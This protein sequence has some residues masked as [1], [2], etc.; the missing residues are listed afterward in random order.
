MMDD[1]ACTHLG[2]WRMYRT[3]VNDPATVTGY[4][5][6]VLSYVERTVVC[7]DCGDVIFRKRWTGTQW[8]EHHAQ[9]RANAPPKPPRK[10][11]HHVVKTECMV[12]RRK[13]NPA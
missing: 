10:C 6:P 13:D 11:H 3:D 7:I 9:V 8:E 4:Q 5:T 12:C 2:Q 1:P